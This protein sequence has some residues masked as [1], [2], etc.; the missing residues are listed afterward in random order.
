MIKKDGVYY[1]ERLCALTELLGELGW[2]EITVIVHQLEKNWTLPV[3]CDQ[4][5]RLE[6]N[7]IVVISDMMGHQEG[8]NNTELEPKIGAGLG[9]CVG[10]VL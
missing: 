1:R 3:Y 6:L 10:G 2:D 4:F 9:R 7:L 5:V 8:D